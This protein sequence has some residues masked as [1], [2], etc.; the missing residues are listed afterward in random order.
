VGKERERLAK[1]LAKINGWI[2]GCEAKLGNEKFTANAPEDVVQKQRELLEEN[3]AKA[4]TLKLR[5]RAL[6]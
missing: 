5:L 6:G 3:R 2:K 1:E 4:D